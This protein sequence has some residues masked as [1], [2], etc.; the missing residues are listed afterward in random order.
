[1]YTV[2]VHQAARGLEDLGLEEVGA[3]GDAVAFEPL[4]ETWEQLK[5]RVSTATEGE[6][7][8]K[9]GGAPD[10]PGKSEDHHEWNPMTCAPPPPPPPFGTNWTRRVPHPVL[11]GHAEPLSPY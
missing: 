11:I 4:Y 10:G 9:E 3:G 1:V 6:A 7:A 8:K 5:A 2:D